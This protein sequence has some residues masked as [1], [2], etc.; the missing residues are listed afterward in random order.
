MF[1]KKGLS[2]KVSKTGSIPID[3]K[4][5]Q[6]ILDYDKSVLGKHRFQPK[7]SFH[8]LFKPML[9]ILYNQWLNQ[10]LLTEWEGSV[11]LT[12]LY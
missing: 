5:F 7:R 8:K 3:S 4:S 12:S 6:K 2:V 1:S 11:Q 10:G 9:K